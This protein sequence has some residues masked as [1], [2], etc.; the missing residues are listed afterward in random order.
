MAIDGEK[1]GV[2]VVIFVGA[3]VD[4]LVEGLDVGDSD[5]IRVGGFVGTDDGISE[6]G[7]IGDSDGSC[8]S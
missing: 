3:K 2:D 6:S 5:I 7:V 8:E 1:E 4:G